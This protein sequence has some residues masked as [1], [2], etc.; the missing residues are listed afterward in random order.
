MIK[1]AL[2]IRITLLRNGRCHTRQISSIHTSACDL[3]SVYEALSYSCMRPSATLMRPYSEM[4]DAIAYYLFYLLPHSLFAHVIA[5]ES[6][7]PLIAH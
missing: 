3:K 4:A 2:A 7:V 5:A 1:A 6:A